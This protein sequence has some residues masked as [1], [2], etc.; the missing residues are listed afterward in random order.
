MLLRFDPF[1][2]VER[3]ADEAWGGRR[4]RG[5]SM[6]ID[7]YREGQEFVALVD[8]PGVDPESIEMS[9]AKK[10]LS[11]D[12]ERHGSSNQDTQKLISERVTG[13][14]TRRLYLGDGIDLDQIKAAYEHGVLKVT[15]PVAEQALPRKVSV[16]VSV[17]EPSPEAQ[18]EPTPQGE[19]TASADAA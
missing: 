13:H 6:P 4:V 16:S 12:A 9:V 14:F 10:V 2:E 19:E 8:L 5:R 3:L 7:V 15:I 17:P 11:V 1:R 18:G